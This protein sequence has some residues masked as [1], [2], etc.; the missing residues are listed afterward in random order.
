V[1]Q[2]FEVEIKTMLDFLIDNIYMYVVVGG[3]VFQQSVGITMGTT[4]APLL[5]DL[6][7]YEAECIQKLRYAKKT[8][9]AVTLNPT[10]D[11]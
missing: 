10:F 11:I 7:L 9:L 2:Y 1:I 4:C 3:Q 8:F 6:F 5:A